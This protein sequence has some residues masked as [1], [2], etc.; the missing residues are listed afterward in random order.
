MGKFLSFIALLFFFFKFLFFG[1]MACGILVPDQGSNLHPR[2]WKHRVLTTGPP[3][4]LILKDL[5]PS[6]ISRILNKT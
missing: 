5:L 3:G 6:E 1:C 4:K 2:Q